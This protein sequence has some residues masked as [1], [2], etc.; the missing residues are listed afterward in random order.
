MTVE[1]APVQGDGGPAPGD[2][3]GRRLLVVHLIS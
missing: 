1:S 2:V 3:M